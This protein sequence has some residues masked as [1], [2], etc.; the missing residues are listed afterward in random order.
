VAIRKI[1]LR[2][3]RSVQ[4]TGLP[5]CGKLNV[6]IGK[7]NA[8]KSNLL[9]AIE[10]TLNHLREGRIAGPWRT[11]GRVQAEFT[12][13]DTSVPVSI[14]VEFDLSEDLNAQLRE[15]LTKESPHL[16]RAIEQIKGHQT[17][18]VVL[19]GEVIR[20]A[21]YLFVEELVIGTLEVRDS[22]V[23]GEGIRL[24]KVN[25]GVGFELYRNRTTARR[26]GHDVQALE[27]IRSRSREQTEFIFRQPKEQRYLFFEE[28]LRPEEEPLR[29]ELRD[30]V[31][32]LLTSMDT[33]E[34]FNNAVGQLVLQTR[35]S[36]EAAQKR[37]VEGTIAAF[38]GDAKTPPAYADW[39]LQQL[40]SL[41]FIHIK[42]TKEPIGREEAETLLKLKVRRGGPDRLLVIQNTVRSLLGVSVD[43]F[44]SETGGQAPEMDVDDFLVEANG[45]GI[46]EALRLILDLELKNPQLA[47]IEEP[48]IHLHPGLSRVVAAYLREKS[49]VTQMFVTTHSTDFIDSVTFKNVVL[50]TQDENRRTICHGVGADVGVFRI[51][52]ELGLRLSTVFMFERLIF[53]EGPSDEAVFRELARKLDLDLAKWQIGFVYMNGV[54]NFAHFAAEGTIEL[55]SRRRIGMWFVVDRDERDDAEVARMVERLGQN[56][57]L[58]VLRKRELENYLLYEAAIAALVAEKSKLSG[59]HQPVQIPEAGRI[60]NV[61]R[62]ELASLKDE[63]I[64]LRLEKRLLKPVFLH[65]R[66]EE[67]TIEERIRAGSEQLSQRL[68]RM[69]EEKA[70]IIS[71]VERE[72]GL[73]RR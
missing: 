9:S 55:L 17:A 45:A 69:E 21:G 53:V 48:E 71:E 1:Q 11:T 15:R 22:R 49:E 19:G 24:L 47:L 10:L 18:T 72:I 20:S 44:E 27:G 42:E 73:G 68:S 38:A 41:P 14:G 36:M 33:V 56:A 51:P 39:L 3:Y 28:P 31:I 35:A 37:E 4:A 7:N 63:V 12:N 40:G 64:R 67:G 2:Q 34:E 46:R 58:V 5:E 66:A 50:V 6:L 70:A 65:T 60:E 30:R 16:E 54:R 25:K 59:A 32:P 57:K 8:G 52:S 43:A 29:P 62:E 23:T 13:R 26:L 61:I